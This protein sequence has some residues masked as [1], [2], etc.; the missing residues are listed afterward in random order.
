MHFAGYRGFAIGL[1]MQAMG[2]MAGAGMSP[3]KDYGYLLIAMRPDLL[4]PLDTY[5]R[6]FRPRSIGS[7]R[8]RE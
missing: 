1:A 6:S 4:V 3:N 5:R 8:R 2:V 7:S